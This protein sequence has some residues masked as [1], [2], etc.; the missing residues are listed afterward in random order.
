MHLFDIDI[1]GKIKFCESEVLS[2]GNELTTFETR[3]LIFRKYIVFTV[4]RCKSKEMYFWTTGPRQYNSVLTCHLIN[5]I[6]S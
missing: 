6:Q 5:V 1:P 4:S 2:P 3:M